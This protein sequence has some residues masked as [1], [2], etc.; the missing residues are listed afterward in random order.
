V[1]KQQIVAAVILA[2][3]VA[4]MAIPRG[5]ESTAEVPE[6]SAPTVVATAENASASENPD[7]V[8]VRARQVQ[9]EAYVERIRVRGRTQAQRHVQV[10]AEQAG[11]IV[12]DPI[13]RGARVEAGD[14]LCEIAVDGRDKALDEAIARQEE[15]E[16]EYRAAQ[17]L[18]N[19]NLQSEIQVAQLRSAAEG[20]ETAVARAELALANT[21]MLAPFTGKVEQRT[22]EI[23]DLLNVGDICAS[24]LDDD[25]MLLV[26]LVPEQNVDRVSVGAKV[27][28]Q[29]LS[30][31]QLTG[32]VTFLASAAD[33]VSRSYRVEVTVNQTDEP[34]REGI[35]TEMQV[36]AAEITAHRIPASSL[37]LDDAGEI[38]VKLIADDNE[39]YFSNVEIVGDETDQMNPSVWVTGLQGTVT[40]ITVGQEVVFPGQVVEADFS[41][42]NNGPR[43]RR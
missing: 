14:L 11:R 32:E 42:A 20:A 38:G 30:G 28:A 18:Q 3:V 8:T 15:A 35:T 1:K 39:V 31:R 26:G 9:P 5:S 25:P 33:E 37:T 12:S 41:W 7:A 17:N 29:L 24:V 40:L 6:D 16:L 19:R 36:N 2:V 43:S 22:V 10:R 4:W 34:I 27:N 23:G 21:K 13:P